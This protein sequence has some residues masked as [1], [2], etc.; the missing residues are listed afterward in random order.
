M[1]RLDLLPLVLA[2]AALAVMQSNMKFNHIL[3]I[4]YE[5]RVPDP[6]SNLP[7]CHPPADQHVCDHSITSTA[8][9]LLTGNVQII[10]STSPT[11][12]KPIASIP[13]LAILI[14][15]LTSVCCFRDPRKSATGACMCLLQDTPRTP[16]PDLPFVVVGCQRTSGK[17]SLPLSVSCACM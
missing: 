1:V 7:T 15:S 3:Q 4:E 8:A 5:S 16:R 11:C 13:L 17:I 12:Y 14:S 10:Q 2:D 9:L 6:F